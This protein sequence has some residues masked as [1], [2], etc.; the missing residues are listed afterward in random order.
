MDLRSGIPFWLATNGILADYPPLEQD[1]PNEEIVIIGSGISGALAAHELCKAGFRCTM[2]DKRMLSS[3]STW[4]STAQIN[5]EIDVMLKDLAAKYDEPF[6]AACYQAS[7][8]SVTSL[9]KVFLETGVGA[10]F[11]DK[12]SLY[13]ASNRKGEKE[14]EEEL[15]IRTRN[16]MPAAYVSHDQLQSDYQLDK[17]CA[18]THE[19]AAQL[20]A[21]KAAAGLIKHHQ[22]N[23]N[24]TVYTRTGI[25]KLQPEKDSVTLM[26]D[27]GHTIK[28][29]YVVCAPGYEAGQFIPQGL[30]FFLYSTYALVTQPLPEK[31]FWKDKCQ[32]WETARPYFYM[33]TTQDNRIMMGGQDSIFKNPAV[34]DALLE[35]KCRKI[36]EQFNELFPAIN[37]RPDFTWCGTFSFTLDGLPYI[38]LHPKLD[39][40]YFALG[41][42]GNGTTFSMIAAEMITNSLLGKPDRRQKLF[43]FDR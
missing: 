4:A 39:N 34:R 31:V 17:R 43:G 19:H 23:G 26:T 24:L 16:H 18:L 25:D 3:G 28:A 32:I 2:I 27:N 35:S 40:V 13:V 5:Y 6:A 7:F 33:R 36:L 1:L 29:R 10:G 38:G 15:K 21:Y 12:R 30:K 37:V 9:K 42:G 11:E 14:I 8:E 41:Y 20:D 22:Q